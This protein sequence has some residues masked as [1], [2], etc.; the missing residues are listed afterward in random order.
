MSLHE[1]W[2]CFNYTAETKLPVIDGVLEIPKFV[3]GI[4]VRDWSKP[5]K[6]T[7][8][9]NKK[10]LNSVRK[11][12]LHPHII[13]LMGVL[14]D[15]PNLEE[16]EIKN[17]AELVFS[18]IESCMNLRRLTINKYTSLIKLKDILRIIP[19][20]Q[21]LKMSYIPSIY[22]QEQFANCKR[23]K[24][25]WVLQEG[26]EYIQARVFKNCKD[27][28]NVK[29][30]KSLRY[31]NMYAFSGCENIRDFK[32]NSIFVFDG[33]EGYKWRGE[34]FKEFLNDSPIATV[35]CPVDYPIN[36][37]KRHL[38]PMVKIVEEGRINVSTRRDHL[39]KKFKALGEERFIRDIP[40]NIDELLWA[41]D[42]MDDGAW[43]VQVIN[44]VNS[45]VN[46]VYNYGE[47]IVGDGLFFVKIKVEAPLVKR[48]EIEVQDI[49]YSG[50]CKESF[51]KG[52]KCV[53]VYEALMKNL[54]GKEFGLEFLIDKQEII[55]RIKSKY[56]NREWVD[57]SIERGNGVD[58]AILRIIP[59]VV[60]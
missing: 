17:E 38:N 50:L 28:I 39:L 33:E 19:N 52:K 25:S 15:F 41:L 47:R 43:R 20:L 53:S 58:E 18:G 3:D 24:P 4:I 36:Y 9:Y 35:Y 21:E 5:I 44:E 29:L 26:V 51:I 6:Y 22:V 10:A 42:L 32:I 59:H 40:K 12:I 2:A 56:N 31:L 8:D 45:V 48:G 37:L 55:K 49:S 16:L 13:R 7:N 1:V 46:C 60:N 27:F 30:P 23:L 14:S 54:V 34:T 57:V 11:I